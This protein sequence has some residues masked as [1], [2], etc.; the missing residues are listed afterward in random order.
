MLF[1]KKFTKKVENQEVRLNDEIDNALIAEYSR[2]NTVMRD[3]FTTVL[4]GNREKKPKQINENAVIY[5]TLAVFF[6][7]FG[8]FGFWLRFFFVWRR[9]AGSLRSGIP[10]SETP[11]SELP[12]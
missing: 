12:G 11:G 7:F 8:L 10:G 1:T 9:R 3:A 6:W 2:L 5:S 4:T